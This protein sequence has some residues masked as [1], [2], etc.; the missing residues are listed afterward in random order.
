LP[1]MMD[2]LEINSIGPGR[3]VRNLQQ[4]RTDLGQL[5]VQGLDYVYTLQGWLKAVNPAMGGTLVNGTDTT[6]AFPVA[7]DVMGY[8]LHYYKK[9]Y[10][11]IG[12]TTKTSSILTALN[13]NVAP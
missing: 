8:S 5:R 12:D 7:Q 9:D 11:A 3:L 13:T 6:E 2:W 4:A 10:S 1:I